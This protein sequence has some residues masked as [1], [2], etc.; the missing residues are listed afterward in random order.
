MIFDELLTGFRMPD[1][2]SQKHYGVVPDLSIF[3]KAIANGHILAAV[4][5][6][7]EV[8]SMVA[9]VGGKAGYVGTFNGHVHSL[10]AG[11]AAMEMLLDGTIREILDRRTLYLKAK[12]EESAD[13]YGVKAILKGRGGHLQWYFTQEVKNYRDAVRSNVKNYVSFANNMLDQGILV[14]PKPLSH[15]AISISHNDE[16]IEKIANAMD[17][18]LKRGNYTV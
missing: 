1:G 6:K 5:G 7:N 10:A 13:K 8:M 17:N 12:F 15:H 2:S 14:I 9:P 4:A 16:V 18:A 3:G 11:L